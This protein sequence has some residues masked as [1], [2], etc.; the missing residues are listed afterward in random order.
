MAAGEVDILINLHARLGEGPRWDHRL[1]VLAWVDI[2][3]GHVHLSDPDTGTT[4]SIPV[5]ADVGAVALLGEGSYLL[6]I[7]Q[8]FAVLADSGIDE[9]AA[10][11]DDVG[12]R[13]NDGVVDPAG[14]FVAGSMA[15]DGRPEMGSLH[16]RDVDGTVRTLFDGVSISNGLAWSSSGDRM[17]Y[18]DSG[19]QRI[20]VMDYD[21]ASG[22]V[23]GRRPWVEVPDRDGTPDGITIDAEDC[24]WVALWDGGTVRRYS[25]DGRALDEIELPVPRVTACEFGGHDLDRLFVTTAAVGR[26]ESIDG[27]GPDGA[28]FVVDPAC[29]GVES[30]VVGGRA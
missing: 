21:V 22:A 29:R 16:Q 15:R 23:S 9:Y 8:G 6:A 3:G 30:V 11:F 10:A 28:V 2:L 4:S 1:G 7:R 26:G 5:G 27:G 17:F 12:L 25:P 13:M 18:V 24:L 14:R 19:L 20:D